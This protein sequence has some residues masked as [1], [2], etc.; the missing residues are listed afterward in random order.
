MKNHYEGMKHYGVREG[1]KKNK[2]NYVHLVAIFMPLSM[3]LGLFK[4]DSLSVVTAELQ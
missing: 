4:V 3:S 2:T 1:E